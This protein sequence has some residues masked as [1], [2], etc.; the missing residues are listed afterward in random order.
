LTSSAAGSIVPQAVG[1]V[2]RFGF[3]DLCQKPLG[4][5][6]YLAIAENFHTIVVDDVPVLTQDDRNAAKRFIT[7]IDA[8][9]T[10]RTSNWLFPPPRRR[11]DSTIGA[12]VGREVFE[13]ERTASRL[14]EMQSHS[15]LA[16]PHGRADSIASGDVTGLVET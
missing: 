10:T 14:I 3:A 4:P 7:F 9:P 11:P 2:A 13:F 6:D 16:L 12:T 1:H 15:Y 5:N 8:L